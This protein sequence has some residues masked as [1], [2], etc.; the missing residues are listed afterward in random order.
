MQAKASGYNAEYRASLGGVISAITKSGGNQ[1]HGERRHLLHRRQPAGRRPAD[2]AAEPD[3]PELAEYVTTPLDDYSS[4]GADLRSR[5]SDPA[6]PALVLRR[7]QPDAGPIA[8]AR[9]ASTTTGPVGTFDQTAD[10]VQHPEL[11]RHR[12]DHAEPARP[13]RG[14]EPARRG[15]LR[16]AD[17]GADGVSTPQLDALSVGHPP[18]QLQRFVL[19]RARLG[20][21]QPDLRQ[22]HD[23]ALQGRP[24]RCRHIQRRAASHVPGVA[25][26]QFC[27]R[28]PRAAAG[29]RL[30]RLSVELAF[31]EGRSQSL[32][33]QRRRHALRAT[34]AASTRSRAAFSSNA[35]ST[36]R[37][38]RRAG[39]DGAAVLGLSLRA[40]RR[41]PRARHVRLLQRRCASCTDRRHRVEQRRPVRAGR[42]DGAP[43]S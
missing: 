6:G 34:G 7:L 27:P 4:P 38:S 43:A 8:A 35:S 28:F 36:T 29:E 42:V 10:R 9:C 24:A 18:R 32:Q 19:R 12:P 13:V 37:S 1:Y 23:D 5:R 22:R 39:V 15:R 33:R 20:G 16:A 17:I 21:Q 11:Q 14:V 3:E 40:Q 31:R 30:R 25:T 26:L 2:A 41:P